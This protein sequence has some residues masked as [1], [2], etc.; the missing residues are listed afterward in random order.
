MINQFHEKL[1]KKKKNFQPCLVSELDVNTCMETALEFHIHYHDPTVFFHHLN[2]PMGLTEEEQFAHRQTAS[3]VPYQ[4][5][6][7]R[8]RPAHKSMGYGSFYVHQLPSFR[9]QENG[10][11]MQHYGYLYQHLCGPLGRGR[12]TTIWACW[13]S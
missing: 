2:Q 4:T 12:N 11:G 8:T 5:E 3:F 7:D 1:R 9:L 10:L 6:P 13:S